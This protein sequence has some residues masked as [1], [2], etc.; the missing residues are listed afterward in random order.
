MLYIGFKVCRQLN[1]CMS[2]FDFHI[3]T[4]YQVIDE[5]WR[6]G[7]LNN[8]TLT[9]VL[10]EPQVTIVFPSHPHFTVKLLK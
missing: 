8:L 6:M 10:H 4:Y 3:H 1:S 7:S 2:H 9:F 5:D